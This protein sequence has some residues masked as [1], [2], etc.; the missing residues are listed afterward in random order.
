MRTMEKINKKINKKL[1]KRKQFLF[2]CL[3]E[4]FLLLLQVSSL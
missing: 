2:K 4:I 3:D 1:I